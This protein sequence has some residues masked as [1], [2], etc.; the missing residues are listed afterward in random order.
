LTFVKSRFLQKEDEKQFPRQ[1]VRR[2]VSG[3]LV[4][5]VPG[6]VGDSRFRGNDMISFVV[7]FFMGGM[8]FSV[9]GLSL[10]GL[11]VPQTPSSKGLKSNRPIGAKYR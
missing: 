9:C 4:F 6:C 2:G 3:H 5:V 11:R 10:M 1:L 8:H 7:M